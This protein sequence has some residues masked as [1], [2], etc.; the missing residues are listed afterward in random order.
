MQG[1]LCYVHERSSDLICHDSFDTAH[2]QIIILS[3][4]TVCY[5]VK[6]A[7]NWLVVCNIYCIM[8]VDYNLI[9]L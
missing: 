4:L 9:V 1:H 2:P 3:Y 8:K 7:T 5:I 6:H